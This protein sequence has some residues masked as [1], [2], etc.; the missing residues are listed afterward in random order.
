VKIGYI[1]LDLPEGKVRFK[2]EYLDTLIRKDNPKKVAPFYVEFVHNEFASPKAIVVRE[3]DILDLLIHDME[4]IETR[5]DRV[6]ETAEKE[7]LERCLTD[8]EHDIPLCDMALNPDERGI[9]VSADPFS[10]KP[11]VK[12]KGSV[13]V[14]SIISRVLEKAGLTFFYTT[15][16]RES[17]AWLVKKQ[18]DI[19]ACASKIH[20]DL[21]KGFIKGDVVGFDDYI[22]RHS[23][24]ECKAMGI[25]K[26][27]DR[28]YV[29]QERD[30]IEIRFNV[31]S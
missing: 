12:V 30:I 7:L 6:T 20:T 17:H 16:P 14:D 27:V 29:V 15:G 23:F 10:L 3:E 4:K 18:S 25:S 9:V 21:A 19:V 2:D 11:V 22:R 8:L 31:I 24:N 13:D 1:G 26:L 28:D 5:L